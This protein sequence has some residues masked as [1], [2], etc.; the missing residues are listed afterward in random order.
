MWKKDAAER[1]K[2]K[3][4]NQGKKDRKDRIKNEASAKNIY[5]EDY[6]FREKATHL[7]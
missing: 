4:G 1:N 6:T 7:P 5:N 2:H 3:H